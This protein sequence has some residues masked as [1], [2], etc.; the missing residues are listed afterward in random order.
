M[1]RFQQEHN[2]P[3]ARSQLK[4]SSSAAGQPVTPTG[5]TTSNLAPSGH[6]SSGTTNAPSF[7]FDGEYGALYPQIADAS[8]PGR[9]AFYQ[10][11]AAAIKVM[12]CRETAG[13]STSEQQR[14]PSQGTVELPESQLRIL[15]VGA[16]GGADLLQIA[17]ALPNAHIT[18]EDTSPAMLQRAMDVVATAD[19]TQLAAAGGGIGAGLASAAA[20]GLPVHTPSPLSSRISFHLGDV[21][22]IAGEVA[23][24]RTRPFHAVTSFLVD[25]FQSDADDAGDHDG[26]GIGGARVR[27]Y[28]AL[29]ACLCPRG[30]LVIMAVHNPRPASTAADA[31][32]EEELAV[33]QAIR[34]RYQIDHGVPPQ[35]VEAQQRRAASGLHPINEGRMTQLLRLAGFGNPCR[36]MAALRT[37]LWMAMK[38]Q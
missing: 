27:Y 31:V 8:I 3:T 26:R 9:A 5:T 14:Q 17:A 2:Q 23:A 4:S 22:S 18:A 13:T 20:A 28:A 1:D 16:G 15:M 25:H 6:T 29:A 35:V 12:C 11:G 32:C 24:G 38:Q 19:G 10:V 30:C 33:I 36:L 7:D 34:E 37:G 21:E